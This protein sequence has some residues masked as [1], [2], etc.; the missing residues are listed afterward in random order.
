M[1]VDVA[2]AAAISR[3]ALRNTTIGSNGRRI[4]D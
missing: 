1:F 2:A 3:A 4:D